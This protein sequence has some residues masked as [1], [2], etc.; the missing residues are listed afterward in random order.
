VTGVG[1]ELAKRYWIRPATLS[2]VGFLADVVVEA[3]RAQGRWRTDVDE[4]EFHRNYVSG[5]RA[6]M[7]GG[8]PHSVTSVIEV[9]GE[10]VGR[11]RIVRDGKRLELSGIQ[12][13]PRVQGRGIGTGIIEDLKS[14]AARRGV[15]L[16]LSVEHDNPRARAL[17]ER[18]GFVKVDEDDNEARFRWRPQPSVAVTSS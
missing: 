10:C 1:E 18:L 6:L 16:E 8:D 12:L 7:E 5:T 14:E 2:D 4:A 11:L 13:L 15:P 9:A 3:T 17:Y